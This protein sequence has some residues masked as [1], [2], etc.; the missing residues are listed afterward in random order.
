M[1]AVERSPAP[2]P[3]PGLALRTGYHSPQIDVEVRLNTNESPEP[4]PRVLL[5][6]L[7]EAT[8]ALELN[9]Y[10]DRRAT[11]LCE[12]IARFHDLSPASVFCANGS[13]EVIQSLLLA[14]GGPGR[15]A[16]VFEPTYALHAHIAR[17]T[18]T[19]VKSRRRD[20]S[21]AINLHDA[22]TLIEA[23]RPDLIMVCSPNN[24][25][26]NA[27]KPE[28]V[29]RIAAAA[30]GLVVIDEAYGQFSS[31]SA[32]DLVGTFGNVAVVRTFSKTWA[33]AALRLG[34][35]LAD[36]E[37][38]EACW[39]V[40]LPYHL[41]ALKQAA[42]VAALRHEPAMLERIARIVGERSRVMDGLRD[43][44][45]DLWPSEASFVLFRPRKVPASTVWNGLVRRSVLV[46]DV[47]GFPGLD[48]CLR[49]TIGTAR[50]NARFLTALAEVLD[51]AQEQ[52]SLGWSV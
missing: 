51:M 17:S 12:G 10:P 23:D 7:S 35:L 33:M 40:A 24:P 48:G 9:R 16:L 31:W 2:P 32:I 50:E 25:T 21:F 47:S 44:P 36:P 26:G 3:R 30:P 8:R 11:A 38:V 4:P 28:T 20:E 52:G 19:A 13:N 45:V 1:S 15:S 34:Y 43:L 5:D 46:R 37:V 49:V 27:E 6:E 22:L 41:D 42:G 14:F 18:G 39:S 29:E